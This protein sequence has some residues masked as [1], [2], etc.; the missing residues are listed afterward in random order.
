MMS[1]HDRARSTSTST[2]VASG[3]PQ[4]TPGK[5]TLSDA[6]SGGGGERLDGATRG[7]M[8]RSFGTDFGHVS[9]HP[10]SP[11][12]SGGTHA[13]TEGSAIHFAPGK[14]EPG[15][16]DGNRLIAHELAHVV[17]Q[18]GGGTAVQRFHPG[19]PGLGHEADADRAADAAVSGGKAEVRLSTRSGV[20][21]NYEA[22]EHR[23]LADSGGGAARTITVDCGITLTYGQVCA[24]S[25][26]FYRSPE[27][28]MHAPRAELEAILRTM[29]R[30]RTEAGVTSGNNF[31]TG[32]PSQ[33]QINQNNADYELATSGPNSRASHHD[34]DANPFL[35]DP[36]HAGGPDAAHP[37]GRVTQGNHVEDNGPSAGAPASAEDA[38]L[39]LADNNASHFS[40]ENINL[41]FKPKHQLAIDLAK[42]AWRTR[43]PGA[44]PGAAAPPPA[45]STPAAPATPAPAGPV[46]TGAATPTAAT[47]STASTDAGQRKE[48]MAYLSDGFAAHFLT[49]AFASGHLVSGSVGRTIGATYYSKH[50][51]TVAIALISCLQREYPAAASAMG[52]PGQIAVIG[53]MSALIATKAG[54]LTLKLVHDYFNQ[55][56]VFVKNPMNTEW[57]TVGDANL[58]S[59]PITQQQGSLAAQAS[60]EG[61]EKAVRDGELSDIERDKPLQYV[62]SEARFA[63]G[64][65]QTISAFC[66][67]ATIFDAVLSATMLSPDPAVNKLWQLIKGNVTPMISLKLKQGGRWVGNLATGAYQAV[68][69]AATTA[70]NA[71]VSGAKTAGNAIV[72]G[73]K[74]A[75]NAVVSG[76]KTAGNAVVHGAEVVGDGVVTGAKAVG[77]GVV[78]GA[79]AVGNGVVSGAQAVDRKARAAAG[80]VSSLFD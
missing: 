66:A 80:W 71:I 45:G 49:D 6:A 3:G 64:S 54:S 15:S 1:E 28:L 58:A 30:E 31:G 16:A 67:D 70:G 40:P 75:G 41:N 20:R 55:N 57:K 73:A 39:G 48:A 4:P 60:R 69:G 9:I 18:S 76:A 74:T 50:S 62:P 56:G 36:D 26:D 34:D 21:Q 2:P 19:E 17:Q 8:E 44:T 24:L 68:A 51:G 25:G 65:Y 72:S 37:H 38:F 52:A 11:K 7:Q 14:Y 61:V 59:S 35:D 42:E 32:A 5:R 33:E 46:P 12:A 10:D 43:N 79:K 13:F 23:A 47:V 63:S 29:D 77:D 78:T 22:W 27:A 53:A